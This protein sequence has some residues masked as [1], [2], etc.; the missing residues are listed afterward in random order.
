MGSLVTQVANVLNV[1]HSS[2]MF[3][4]GPVVTAT[5]RILW[6]VGLLTFLSLWLS[7]ACESVTADTTAT[8]FD[9]RLVRLGGRP[10]LFYKPMR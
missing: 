9:R 1:F 5:A 2:R 7:S 10:N 3:Q 8:S 4:A 6:L